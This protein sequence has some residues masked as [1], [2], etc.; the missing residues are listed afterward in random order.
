MIL[1]YT[2]IGKYGRSLPTAAVVTSNHHHLTHVSDESYGFGWFLRTVDPFAMSDL[3]KY[4]CHRTTGLTRRT[5]S[6][7]QNSLYLTTTQNIKTSSQ[8]E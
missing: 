7:P 4:A 8:T 3:S 5:V 1:Q 6:E 2:Y